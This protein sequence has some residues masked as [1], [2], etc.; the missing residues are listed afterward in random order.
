MG[1]R[2]DDV[3]GCGDGTYCWSRCRPRHYAAD[4]ISSLIIL[5]WRLIPGVISPSRC[6]RLA[7][8][9]RTKKARAR[10]EAVA[11]AQEVGY[12]TEKV[13]SGREVPIMPPQRTGAADSQT[14]HTDCSP[15]SLYQR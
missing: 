7:G 14:M 4:C 8:A 6:F 15:A 3:G 10:D 11:E 12:R 2:F 9:R 5:G 1:A 13:R